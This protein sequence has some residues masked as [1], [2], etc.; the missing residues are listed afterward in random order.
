MSA[1]DP[2]QTSTLGFSAAPIFVAKT[3]RMWHR[4]PEFLTN[5]GNEDARSLFRRVGP[6]L[7]FLNR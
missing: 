2:K 4:F 5:D 6:V 7:D 3:V 1:Y